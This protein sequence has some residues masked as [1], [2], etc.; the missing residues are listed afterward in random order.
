MDIDDVFFMKVMLVSLEL[1][2]LL[3]W[4]V[5][6]LRHGTVG[7]GVELYRPWV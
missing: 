5:L 1:V 3:A 7:S 4:C 6:V 2:A